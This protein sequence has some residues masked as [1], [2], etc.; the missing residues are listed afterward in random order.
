MDMKGDFCMDNIFLILFLISLLALPV[1]AIKTVIAIVKK[2]GMKGKKMLKFSGLSLAAVIVTTIGFAATADT[3]E[4]TKKKAEKV[5]TVAKVEEEEK[6]KPEEKAAREAKEAEEKAL[7]EQ[8]AKEEAEA[9]E[10]EKA[11]ESEKQ[12]EYFKTNAQPFINEVTSSYDKGWNDVWQPTFE[13]ISAG[14]TDIYKA[15]ENMKALKNYYRNLSTN[16]NNI[17]VE[18]LS[19]KHQKSLKGAM[20]DLSYAAVSRQ[21]AAEKAMKMFDEGNYSPSHM[22]KIKS[23]IASADSRMLSAV[24]AITSVKAELGIE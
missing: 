16:M 11:K 14:N 21:M 2:D 7:A 24:V 1:F 4:T 10:K 20:N 15:Y 22:D 23:D 3:V 18:G 9:K 8:K 13:A 19:K 17:P 6:E 5:E 12:V